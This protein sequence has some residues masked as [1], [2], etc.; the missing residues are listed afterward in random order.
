M[1]VELEIELKVE[2]EVEVDVEV[3]VNVEVEL[4]LKVQLEL[5]VEKEEKKEKYEVK[6]EER[7]RKRKLLLLYFE[8]PYDL[9]Q[10]LVDL[11]IRPIVI[12]SRLRTHH[13][14]GK[15]NVLIVK[16]RVQA[17]DG[18][19]RLKFLPQTHDDDQ[20]CDGSNRCETEPHEL[21]TNRSTRFRYIP[22]TMQR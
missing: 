12:E 21:L 9:R 8:Q 1:E 7:V 16:V 5:G 11:T 3:E 17:S 14:C 4:Q 20:R 15:D 6:K 13:S 10:G 22:H 19:I 18:G 2:L